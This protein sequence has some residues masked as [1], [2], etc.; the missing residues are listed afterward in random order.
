MVSLGE[1]KFKERV[2]RTITAEYGDKSG[3]GSSEIRWNCKRDRAHSP[4]RKRKEFRRASTLGVFYIPTVLSL[5][6]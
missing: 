1:T 6:S 4:S 3:I 5:F 2:M